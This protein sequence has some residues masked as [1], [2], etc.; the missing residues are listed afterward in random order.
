MDEYQLLDNKN[1]GMNRNI[2]DRRRLDE[3]AVSGSRPPVHFF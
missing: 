3:V 2:M 1:N